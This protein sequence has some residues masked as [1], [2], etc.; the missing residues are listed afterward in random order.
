MGYPDAWIAPREPSPTLLAL[1]VEE[2]P[3]AFEEPAAPRPPSRGLAK[4][5]EFA[6]YQGHHDGDNCELIFGWAWDSR[7]PDEPIS[8]D[9]YEADTLVATVV[10]DR[11]RPDRGGHATWR[12]VSPGPMCR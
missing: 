12:C 10:A 8:V 9:I 7:R 6:F 5:G 11:F 1:P 2:F 4:D 3:P